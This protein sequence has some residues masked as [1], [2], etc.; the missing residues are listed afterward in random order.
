MFYLD[1]QSEFTPVNSSLLRRGFKKPLRRRLGIKIPRKQKREKSLSAQYGVEPGG[2]TNYI[3][4]R[5]TIQKT[6]YDITFSL[7]I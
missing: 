2:Y 5:N 7:T 4:L 1:L 6:T 3:Y